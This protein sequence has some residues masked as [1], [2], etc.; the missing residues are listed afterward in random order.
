MPSAPESLPPL[1]EQLTHAQAPGWLAAAERAVA[2]AGPADTL[3][4]D[5]HALRSFDSSAL[6]AL[7]ALRRAVL[8]RGLRWRIEGLPQRLRTLASVYGV[9]ALLPA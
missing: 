6:A 9:E 1:P 4:L 2:Q 5:A 8:A 7:L 3:V